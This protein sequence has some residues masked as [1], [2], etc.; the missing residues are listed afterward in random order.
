MIFVA[1]L[2]MKAKKALKDEI[3]QTKPAIIAKN[4]G[5]DSQISNMNLAIICPDDLKGLRSGDL[6]EALKNVHPSCKVLYIYTKDKDRD[7]APNGPNI[8]K[9]QVRRVNSELIYDLTQK[10]LK[11]TVVT[12]VEEVDYTDELNDELA[13]VSEENTESNKALILEKTVTTL[14][15]EIEDEPEVQQEQVEEPE[16]S[17][18][19]ELNLKGP[20]FDPEREEEI[21][22]TKPVT[23][24]DEKTDMD[25]KRDLDPPMVGDRL[26]PDWDAIKESLNKDKIIR[27]LLSENTKYSILTEDILYLEKKIEAIFLD[28][29]MSHED[30]MS[31]IKRIALKKSA[32]IGDA[33]DILTDKIIDVIHMVTN[34]VEKTMDNRCHE[35]EKGLD[36]VASLKLLNKEEEVIN[37]LINSRVDLYRELRTEYVNLVNTYKV[38][39]STVSDFLDSLDTDI[40]TSSEYIN[41]LFKPIKQLFIP[42][43]LDTLISKIK[44]SMARSTSSFST[45]EERMKAIISLLFKLCDS[46]MEIIT[47]QQKLLEL[48]KARRPEERVRMENVLKGRLK[49][50][51]G[52]E[53]SG[54]SSTGS[55]YA[56]LRSRIKNTALIDLRDNVMNTKFKTYTDDLYDLND[57]LCMDEEGEFVKDI[58]K[59]FITVK[60]IVG[61]DLKDFVDKLSI[62][63]DYYGEII[64]LLDGKQKELL[65]YLSQFAL[66]VYFVVGNSKHNLYRMKKLIGDYRATNIAKRVVFIAPPLD[67]LRMMNMLGADKLLYISMSIPYISEIVEYTLRGIPP[68]KSEIAKGVFRGAFE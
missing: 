25:E 66:S 20:E 42:Q 6:A 31:N 21:R 27:D 5:L 34:T 33:E 9:N 52:F 28:E 13:R 41:E 44:D 67:E 36:R 57:F 10:V 59:E 47:H 63:L 65:D 1:S 12:S 17:S 11:D 40:P 53:G 23:E 64:I 24:I 18:L 3:Y 32:S 39:D 55:I 54:V 45:I 51:V 7:L 46:S 58:N 19:D 56:N 60:G 2:S 8:F 48:Y 62:H 49:L 38:V 37:E 16:D 61:E 4:L 35:I 26:Y 30:K 43:N 14:A 22:V 29:S 68:Y 50:F 15:K